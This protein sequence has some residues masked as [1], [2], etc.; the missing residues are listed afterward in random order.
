MLFTQMARTWVVQGDSVNTSIIHLYSTLPCNGGIH[1]LSKITGINL[2]SRTDR[3]YSSRQDP[4][5]EDRTGR[6]GRAEVDH[7]GTDV[8]FPKPS[9][10]VSGFNRTDCHYAPLMPKG[11]ETVRRKTLGHSI[12]DIIGCGYFL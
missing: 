12:C 1:G 8:G 10:V 4:K 2:G 11:S 3:F 5:A 9:C 7:Q 6:V